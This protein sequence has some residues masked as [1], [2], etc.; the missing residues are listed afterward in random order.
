MRIGMEQYFWGDDIDEKQ[1]AESAATAERSYYLKYLNICEEYFTFHDS[2]WSQWAHCPLEDE[3]CLFKEDTEK[4]AYLK[5]E[6]TKAVKLLRSPKQ[7]EKVIE[8]LEH[9]YRY[10]KFPADEYEEKNER[11]RELI[12]EL[13]MAKYRECLKL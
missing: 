3:H 13:H 2:F 7:L 1:L 5:N 11:I 9:E 6:F 12:R 4:L 10:G 8:I